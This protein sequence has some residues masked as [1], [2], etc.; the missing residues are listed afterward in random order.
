MQTIKTVVEDLAKRIHEGSDP[1]GE[2]QLIVAHVLDMD[3]AAVLAHPE[4]PV[5][6][7][8][9]RK[10][11]KLSRQRGRGYSLAVAFGYKDF[12][13]MRFLVTKDTLVPRPETELLVEL[14]LR[15][16]H[17]RKNG[18][19][20]DVGT[21]TGNIIV[22]IAKSVANPDR[23]HF[24]A[25]DISRRALSVASENARRK[26]VSIHFMRSNLFG[27]LKS[28]RYDIIVANLPYLASGEMNE[29]S[30]GREPKLALHGGEH[31]HEL[32]QKFV[33]E[34]PQVMEPGGVAFIEISPVIATELE[35]F[36]QNTL[37]QVRRKIHPD[38]AGHPRVLEL[39]FS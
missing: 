24:F 18:S 32:Y 22:S 12:Y 2:A 4:K 8:E 38:L 20:L 29:P 19:L 25:S 1:T 35:T 34:L 6:Q 23:Y 37:P 10:C 17:E 27:K 39:R 28:R 21:G 14:S 26:H 3:R 15:E 36:C 13:G 5:S 11:I 16:L 31:G 7:T 9:L 33:S 30:I